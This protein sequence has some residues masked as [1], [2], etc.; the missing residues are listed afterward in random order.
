[1]GVEIQFCH[2]VFDDS[3]NVH[4]V[5]LYVNRAKNPGGGYRISSAKKV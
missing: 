4:G 2:F 3:Q 5:V 1:M